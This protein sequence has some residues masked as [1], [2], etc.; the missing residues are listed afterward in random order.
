MVNLI[1][2]TTLLLSSSLHRIAASKERLRRTQIIF[3][4]L[5]SAFH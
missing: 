3:M 4:L 2:V 1:A 5:E